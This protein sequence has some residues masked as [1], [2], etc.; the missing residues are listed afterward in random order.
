MADKKA[1]LEERKKKWM[2]ERE[3]HQMRDEAAKHTYHHR[4]ANGGTSSGGT[5]VP[6]SVYQCRTSS[7][8]DA[9]CAKVAEMADGADVFL[10]KLTDRLTTH[11]RNEVRK[12]MI[13]SMNSDAVKESISGRIDDYLQSELSSHTC[14]ICFEIMVSPE[15]TPILLFPCGHTFCTVCIEA[16]TAQPKPNSAARNVNKSCPY[17][18][19][20][21]MSKAINQSLKE[22]IDQ[23]AKKNHILQ[24]C[25]VTALDDAFPLNAGYEDQSVSSNGRASSSN[26]GSGIGGLV[27]SHGEESTA[28][29]YRGQLKSC[30]MRRTIMR[31]ELDDV[32]TEVEELKR[33]REK[34]RGAY[35]ML[36][37]EK[38]RIDEQMR[39][40]QEELD[41][42]HSHMSAQEQKLKDI[43]EKEVAA[44]EK[45][46]ILTRT[47]EGLDAEL[48]K[49]VLLADA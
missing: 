2:S 24:S 14:K 30:E 35:D 16:H 3:I 26:N 46:L 43:S 29:R 5:M 15:H 32:A 33:K 7:V 27:K 23:F 45:S 9:G 47:V 44:K 41:L 17:C 20:P 8:G 13:G 34:M 36:S 25:G 39:L 11:I 6:S 31:N 21:I 22:L 4:Q 19:E 42:V 12:E 18:R 49:L 40:L 10:N 28:A 37:K 38:R 48:E 1:Q